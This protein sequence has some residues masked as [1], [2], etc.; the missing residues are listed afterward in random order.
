[1]ANDLNGR[2]IAVLA[3]DGFEQSELT[4]PVKALKEAGAEVEVDEK[5]NQMLLKRQATLAAAWGS[6]VKGNPPD[7]KDA[8]TK[9]WMAARK[10]ALTK[11]GMDPIF[12]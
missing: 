3:T 11:V 4:E 2:R 7:D 6:F 12:E 8:F 1:M 5:H 9:G 10:A